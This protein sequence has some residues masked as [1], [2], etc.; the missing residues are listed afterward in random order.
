MIGNT[1]EIKKVGS[2]YV[3]PRINQ[4][5]SIITYLL[6]FKETPN[7]VYI[8][9][10]KSLMIRISQHISSVKRNIKKNK[11]LSS[12][13]EWLHTNLQEAILIVKVLNLNINIEKARKD[14]KQKIEQHIKRGYELVNGNNG[15]AYYDHDKPVCQYNK[16]GMFINKYPSILSASL[17]VNISA[18]AISKACSCP[19]RISAKYYWRRNYFEQINVSKKISKG[20]VISVYSLNGKRIQTFTDINAISKFLQCHKTNVYSAIANRNACK[21]YLINYGTRDNIAV[22]TK[23]RRRRGGR[24]AS[25]ELNGKL[26]NIYQNIKDASE[27]VN[28]SCHAINQAIRGYRTA[29]SLQWRRHL[30]EEDVVSKIPAINTYK[31]IPVYSYCKKGIFVCSYESVSGAA[32]ASNTCVSAISRALDKGKLAAGYQWSKRK[33]NAIKPYSRRKTYF[34]YHK[35]GCYIMSFDS[36]K[37]INAFFSRER[38]ISSVRNAIK[39][40]TMAYGF[41]WRLF[42]TENIEPYKRKGRSNAQKAIT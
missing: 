19:T 41:Q 32:T 30:K 12:K 3:Y 26:N 7:T 8:G 29:G 42:K 23:L 18:S 21:G 34:A 36:P 20:Q 31:T 28:V 25:Y 14:E 10:S 1:Y 38:A 5:N 39:T 22:S 35:D 11:T 4:Q 40:K 9:I 15:G 27:S 24:I 6:Y 16:D 2:R 33:K 17:A 13:E 37:R